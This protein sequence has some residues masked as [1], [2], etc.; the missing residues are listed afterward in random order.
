MVLERRLHDDLSR[1]NLIR[2]LLSKQKTSF[3]SSKIASDQT[4]GL[5]SQL[6]KRI[7]LK[8]EPTIITQPQESLL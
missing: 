5:L 2:Y 6:S 7:Q 4:K 3:P 8:L 1:K